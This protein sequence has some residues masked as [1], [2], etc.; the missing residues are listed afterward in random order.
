MWIDQQTNA[1][2]ITIFLVVVCCVALYIALRVTNKR[3]QRPTNKVQ[4]DSDITP[5]I[6][7]HHQLHTDSTRLL[8]KQ[9]RMDASA[10]KEM[11]GVI[12]LAKNP[13]SNATQ[14]S[15]AIRTFNEL[16][17]MKQNGTITFD[18]YGYVDLETDKNFVQI[19]D[20]RQ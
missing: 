18:P 11:R 20:A 16:N 17:A 9:D 15:C 12:S 19:M 10:E 4:G 13:H 14:L 6:R 1:L 7:E 2:I 5:Y 3:K 8:T